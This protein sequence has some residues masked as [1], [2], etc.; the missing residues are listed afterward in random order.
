MCEIKNKRLIDKM[1]YWIGD[2]IIDFFETS[3]VL[4]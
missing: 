3:K 1:V 4:L 2:N